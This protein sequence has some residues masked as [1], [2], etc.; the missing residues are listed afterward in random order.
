MEFT[1]ARIPITNTNMLNMDFDGDSAN[2]K[3]YDQPACH[4]EMIL[5]ISIGSEVI[6][7]ITG[8]AMIG[9]VQE[10]LV[11]ANTLNNIV[12]IKK[13]DAY[14]IVG[15]YAY[16]LEEK[17]YY[18][19]NELL[20]VII[21]KNFH[22]PNYFKDGKLILK[23][24]TGKHMQANSGS[25]IFT[26]LSKHFPETFIIDF[27]EYYRDLLYSFANYIGFSIGIE[28]ILINID[29]LKEEKQKILDKYE[30]KLI[31][32]YEDIENEK[33]TMSGQEYNEMCNDE[34]KK[35]LSELEILGKEIVK[36]LTNNT[37]I[38]FN[39]GIFNSFGEMLN[40]EIKIKLSD[41]IKIYLCFGQPKHPGLYKPKIG[42]YF[43]PF[44]L[45]GISLQ[46]TG[47]VVDSLID[48]LSFQSYT[49]VLLNLSIPQLIQVSKKTGDAGHIARNIIKILDVSINVFG[50]VIEKN[51][52]IS[53]N[54]NCVKV[55]HKFLNKIKIPQISQSMTWYETLKSYLETLEPFMHI[56]KDEGY[57]INQNIHFFINFESMILTHNVKKNDIKILDLKDTI[58]DFWLEVKKNYYF[59]L[60]NINLFIYIS[61]YFFDPSCYAFG[62]KVN[63]DNAIWDK[64]KNKI[65]Y[66]LKYS[67][68][69][70]VNGILA[71][72]LL[73]T[74]NTQQTLSGFHGT[75]QSNKEIL[76]N[77][78]DI[79]RNLIDPKE[80]NFK[81]IKAYS[82]DKNT[83]IDIIRK[84]EYISLRE[85]IYDIE[86]IDDDLI[87]ILVKND[88]LKKKNITIRI[89]WE[90]ISHA[91]SH[92]ILIKYYKIDVMVE[93]KI[94]IC[95]I[96]LNYENNLNSNIVKLLTNIFIKSHISKGVIN[97][98]LLKIKTETF[99][100][101]N[102]FT[103]EFEIND[104]SDLQYIDTSSLTKIE[105][106]SSSYGKMWSNRK[107]KL[108]VFHRLI[109]L[110]GDE[111]M[112][113]IQLLVDKLYSYKIFLGLKPR[114]DNGQIILN[115]IIDSNSNYIGEACIKNLTDD[116]LSSE[117]SALLGQRSNVG[118]SQYEH[119]FD[120]YM[121]NKL[122]LVDN[123]VEITGDSKIV[124]MI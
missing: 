44:C 46:S 61:L 80:N 59:N 26:I 37:N 7:R 92:F 63:L 51:T 123:I 84:F 70:R 28:D 40:S 20:S 38:N 119:L 98:I 48:G 18:S 23:K 104:I 33:I 8:H 114:A 6:N 79:L 52:I 56:K 76:S 4:A 27:V 86:F 22:Y 10:C 11:V 9:L 29:D 65:L 43:F 55:T 109:E 110:I 89:L 74:I 115:S 54:Y 12:K 122:Q 3:S 17:E 21:P 25:S 36:R 97:N 99:E 101:K 14:Y 13:E 34:N 5:L 42:G 64:C 1:G 15:K 88:I 94:T 120:P 77:Y 35:M 91:F 19:G 103:L 117:A 69:S 83:L 57:I 67:I 124:S 107:Q 53:L 32:T 31:M 112:G 2:T 95:K 118:K 93:N 108:Q 85:I 58:I 105:L 60:I 90:M 82:F 73:Q 87:H 78:I 113:C 106:P 41:I 66:A 102:I 16:L 71:A 121:F 116:C 49:N 96:K 47:F 111:N 72:N 50:H 100:T 81:K 30:K 24:I 39:E 75:D 45:K 68:D 62:E